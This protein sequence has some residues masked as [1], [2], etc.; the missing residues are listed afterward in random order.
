MDYT[1][2]PTI[3]SPEDLKHLS[4]QQLPQLCD[5]LRDYV[6]SVINKVG[7][8][9]APTLGVVELT[10]ALHYLYNTPQDRIVW[11]VGHQAYAH[12]VLTGRRDRLHTIRH[13]GGLAPFCRPDESEYDAFGAGHAST[14]ISAALGIATARDLQK[15][16]YRVAAVVGDGAIT[17]GLAYEGLNNAGTM[18]RQMT[19]IL[20][21]NEMSISPNVGAMH[22]LLTKMVTNPIYNKIRD[23]LWNF[24]GKI[25]GG[26][27]YVRYIVRK[28]EEGLKNF[29]TPGI[30]FE[31]LGFRYIGPINGH[32]IN[33]LLE[34]LDAVKD[35]K[36]P[37]LVHI[38]TEKGKGYP[39][40]EK[41]PVRYHSVKG[42]ASQDTEQQSVPRYS[43]VFGDI[44]VQMAA[45]DDKIV[46]ITPAMREGSGLVEFSTRFPDRYFDVGIAEGHAVTFAAGLAK[47]GMQPVV[48]IYSSFLQRGYDH[49][50][51]DVAIQDLPVTFCL[52]RAGLVGGDGATHHGVFD[53]SYMLHIP[54]LVVSA[55]KDGNELWD[56]MHTARY[57]P[58][59]FSIRYPKEHAGNFDINREP[60]PLEIGTWE[61]ISHGEQVVILAVGSMVHRARQAIVS[62][63]KEGL[64]VGLIN[65][66]FIKPMDTTMLESLVTDYSV[67]VTLEENSIIGGFG[68]EIQRT[69]R[70]KYSSD[71]HITQI[72][73]PDEFI[74][75][76]SRKDLLNLVG[77]SVDKLTERLRQIASEHHAST[78]E[79]S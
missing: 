25:P 78:A 77:L 51:H 34:T 40:V 26:S 67:I 68:S 1:L 20:N 41:S 15:Q 33:E 73:L 21:D 44:L 3:D 70:E 17:G 54:N 10:V 11:D 16:D 18:K 52:D 49:L 32:D 27:R 64:K 28:M 30:L 9:L 74:G 22:H 63:E 4:R 42:T 8:H 66:R 50:V 23:E 13:L 55:P 45:T 58:R 76:G 39:D 38:L 46:G 65:V 69:V 31:E 24:T 79:V 53:L 60:R 43:Q 6:I 5:E 35:L 19:I 61:E 59:P 7:G 48:A 12:K 29:L 14:A 72:G 56:L 37:A 47:E 57:S 2:L 36:T 71:V 75:H 62:L